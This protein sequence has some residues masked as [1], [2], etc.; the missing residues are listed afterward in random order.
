MTRNV[1]L[2]HVSYKSFKDQTLRYNLSYTHVH[3]IMMLMKCFSKALQ[4]NT[5]VLHRTPVPAASTPKYELFSDTDSFH[6]SYALPN[7]AQRSATKT[8]SY[9]SALPVAGRMGTASTTSTTT[10]AASARASPWRGRRPRWHAVRRGSPTQRHLRRQRRR[11]RPRR[12]GAA[13]PR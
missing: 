4:C 13:C 5:R 6:G 12:A 7:H 8:T 11:R 9:Y 1:T 10:T 3:I 2:P